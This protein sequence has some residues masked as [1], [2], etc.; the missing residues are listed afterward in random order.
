M[1]GAALIRAR[2]VDRS[3]Q[4]GFTL[5]EMLV[6]M[7]VIAILLA[8]AVPAML[9]QRERAKDAAASANVRQAIAA[10][11]A[12]HQDHG[13]YLGMT[14]P[15]LRASYDSGLAPSIALGALTPAAYCV[16]ATV[17]GH[18]WHVNGPGGPDVLA[19]SC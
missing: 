3:R 4:D 7:A 17:D 14:V 16:Q 9:G 10:V 15:G 8:I 13:T 12:Y 6:V 18:T 5:I 2:I 19:G 1:S 11:E